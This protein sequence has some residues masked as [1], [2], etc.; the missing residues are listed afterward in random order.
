MIRFLSLPVLAVLLLAGVA[1][2][3]GGAVVH[4]QS[5]PPQLPTHLGAVDSQAEMWRAVRQGISGTTGLQDPKAGTLVQS[6]GDNLRAVR[7]GPVSVWGGWLMLGVVVV[8][9]VFFAV[10]GRI[11]IDAGPSGLTIERFTALERFVHWLTAISFIVLALTGLNLLYGKIVL[12]PILGPAI[13]ATLTAWG[14]YAHNFI[15]VA[16]MAGVLLMLVLWVQHNIPTTRDLKWLALGGGLFSKGVH[17]PAGKFN[18]GQKFIFW[19]VIL[20]GGSI[21]FSGICLLLPFEIHPFASTFAALNALGADLPT[22]LTPLQETQ[23]ALLWHGV[24]ALV[25]IAII[26]GH[27]Y[28]G[29]I[30]MEG[31]LDA[32]TSGQ[33]D[34]NWAREHHSVWLESVQERRAAGGDD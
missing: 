1:L 17:P 14:K 22:V 23:L 24:V 15:S 34:V 31:A 25:L 32:M 10:R 12:K 27:I 11:R 16:F 29:T 28:I 6:E 4:A 18:A 33:V 26:I 9:A 3:G 5:A 20:A 7:N 2:L 21:S 19:A 30:G 8:L 13:F